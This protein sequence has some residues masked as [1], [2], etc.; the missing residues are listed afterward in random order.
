MV[1]INFLGA[2]IIGLIIWWFWLYK[3][4]EIVFRDEGLLITLEN[5]VYSPSRIKLEKEKPAVLTFLRKDASPCAGHV[6]IPAFDI[7]EI[8]P[9]NQPVS[10]RL[11][12]MQEGEYSFHC[13]MQMYRGELNVT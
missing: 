3:P 7:S 2:V 5:G 11:P 10:I 1:I 9:M 8:L 4:K 13:Q 6:L 12:K